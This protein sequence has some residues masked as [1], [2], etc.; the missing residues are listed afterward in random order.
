M[1]IRQIAKLGD[2]ILREKA[3]VVTI[4]DDNLG[5][6]LDDMT[7]TMFFEEGVGLA[8]PQVSILKR[9]CVISVDGK[10]IYELVNPEIIKSSGTQKGAEGCLSIPNRNGVV[11]RPKEITVKYQDRS[12]KNKEITVSDFTAVAFCH[13]I[14]HL[15][16][17][18]F[19]DKITS[20][21]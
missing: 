1:A 17:V 8:A 12:G 13:E 15:N 18:L 21:Q 3:K 7:E 2:S 19:I 4:F 16:G 14:D 6:L 20:E 9:I 5:T 10:T 11:E